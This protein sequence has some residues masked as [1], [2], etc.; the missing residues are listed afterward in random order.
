MS[1]TAPIADSTRQTASSN[2]RK[3]RPFG[4]SAFVSDLP[5]AENKFSL[6]GLIHTAEPLA[7]CQ[8]TQFETDRLLS[9][10][11]ITI[12]LIR[13][14]AVV[15]WMSFQLMFVPLFSLPPLLRPNSQ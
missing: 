1:I 3:L 9:R 10:L 7:R 8:L 5:L 4:I 13:A 12:I 15:P 11:V 2:W 14:L 6:E